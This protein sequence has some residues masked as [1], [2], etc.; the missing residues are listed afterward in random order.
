MS[1]DY[2]KAILNYTVV[3]AKLLTVRAL[4]VTVLTV[5]VVKV[6]V[7]AVTVLTLTLANVRE[8]VKKNAAL[9]WIFS[10]PGLTPPPGI[11]E[12]LGH[13]SEG[14]FFF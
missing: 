7:M 14:K 6:T 8:A 13:F 1:S 5:M 4:T 3:T 9:I 2:I 11:L 10:K 12:L